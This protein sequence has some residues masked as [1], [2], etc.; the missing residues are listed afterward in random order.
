MLGN[1]RKG[2]IWIGTWGGVCRFTG[3]GF[4]NFH[5]PKPDVELLPYQT[6]MNWSTEIMED[7]EG[8][9][10][11]GRGGYGATKYDGASFTHFTKKDGLASNNRYS[12]R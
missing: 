3:S 7:S 8:N 6:T 11:F 4:I 5:I 2:N 9:I 1:D 10:W 12:G